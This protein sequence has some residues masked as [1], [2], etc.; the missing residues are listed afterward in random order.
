M[1][2]S[3]LGI[4]S[5]PVEEILKI[6]NDIIFLSIGITTTTAFPDQVSPITLASPS[7]SEFNNIIVQIL[8]S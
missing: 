8:K 6:K 7:P 3:P 5:V 2:F 4:K 1:Y